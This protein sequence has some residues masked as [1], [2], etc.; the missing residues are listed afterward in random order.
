MKDSELQI[1]LHLKNDS[2]IFAESAYHSQ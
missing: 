2:N 1:K